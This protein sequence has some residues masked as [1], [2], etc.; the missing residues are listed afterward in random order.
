MTLSNMNENV[1]RLAVVGSYPVVIVL[2]FAFYMTLAGSGWHLTIA[3]YGAALVGVG[4]IALHEI[5]LPY[6]RDW[7]PRA[8]DVRTDVLFVIV[9]QAALPHLL[10]ITVVIGLAGAIQAGGLAIDIFWPHNIPIV[11]QV[12]MMLL[13]ADFMRYWL[14]R[15]FH[16][17]P[18]MWRLHAVHH[19]PA[20][21]YTFNVGRFH[22]IEKSI[23]YAV[24]TLP[25]ALLGVSPE[26]LA[27]YFV[28]YALNGFFQH[29]NCRVYLG[30]LNYVVAGPELHRWHHSRRARESNQ[31][32][33]NNLIVWDTL[34]GTRFL[35]KDRDVEEI[36][37][38]NRRYPTG[39]LVQMKSPFVREL[40]P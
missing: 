2:G 19:S 25:F 11:V 22:P 39:F 18:R 29:S 27:A 26:V 35:P 34:F 36:G 10:A 14:H 8:Q 5:M 33:G 9:V 6:R 7:R 28:F 12:A 40:L 31:N 3:S 13:A 23:Q 20:Q 24:D 21:L 17:Y 37:L 16:R 38:R 30:P 4:L 15:A 32:F 1:S